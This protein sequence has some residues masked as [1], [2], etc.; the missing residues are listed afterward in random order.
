MA[1]DLIISV[2]VIGPNSFHQLGQSTFVF[3]VNLCEGNSGACLPMDQP[4]QP[5]LSLDDAVGDPHL[6]T[7]SRQEDHQLN[8]VYVVGN[9][10]QLSL[11]VLYQSGDCIDARSKDRWSLSRDI[12]FAGSFLL[13][14]GQQPLLLFL[15][16][17]WP[18]LVGKFKQLGSCLP[19]QGLGELVNGRRNFEPLIE[20]GPLPLQP[21]VAGPF[22]EAREISLGLDVLPNAEVLRPLLNKGFTTFFASCFF[23]TAGG[24]G[25]LLPLGLLSLGHLAG[26]EERAL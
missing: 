17:L 16:G 10:H 22:D 18:V 14:T 12:P 26:L 23:T 13:S 20:D 3:R 7:Q 11:L 6:A 5:G 4:P 15:L 1:A 19:V 24:R 21:N 25:H 2:V 9:H 8:G